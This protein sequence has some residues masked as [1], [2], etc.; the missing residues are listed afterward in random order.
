M[1]RYPSLLVHQIVAGFAINGQFLIIRTTT[2]F[3]SNPFKAKKTFPFFNHKMPPFDIGRAVEVT[4]NIAGFKDIFFVARIEQQF[5]ERNFLVRYET[6]LDENGVG[7][8]QTVPKSLLRPIPPLV[9][10]VPSVGD[11]VDVP[12][13]NGW[14]KATILQTDG[15][16]VLAKLANYNFVRVCQVEEIR[17]HQIWNRRD[18]SFWRYKKVED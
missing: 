1:L 5:Y 15:E 9:C 10:A 7:I 2:L 12:M 6:L 18:P 13:F 3:V 8:T 17:M 11:D 16:H 14:W 4:P